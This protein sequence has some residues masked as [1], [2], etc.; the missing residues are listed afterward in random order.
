MGAKKRDLISFPAGWVADV[1]HGSQAAEAP[2]PLEQSW[3]DFYFLIRAH[4]DRNV[5]HEQLFKKCSC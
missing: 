5:A 4:K 1:A 2:R 3:T